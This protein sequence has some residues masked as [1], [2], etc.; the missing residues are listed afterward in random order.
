MS[1]QKKVQTMLT[2]A[3]QQNDEHE[4]IRQKAE[5][6]RMKKIISEKLKDPA[7]A[8]KAALIISDMLKKKP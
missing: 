2:P 7:M 6:E 4:K 8:K 1:A 5:I 3:K